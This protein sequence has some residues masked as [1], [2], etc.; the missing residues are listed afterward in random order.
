MD[1]GL[2]LYQDAFPDDDVVW[3]ESTFN[4]RGHNALT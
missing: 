2:V 1:R 4:T 3:G